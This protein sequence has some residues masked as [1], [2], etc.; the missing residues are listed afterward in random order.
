MELRLIS[1]V[2]EYQISAFKMASDAS[3]Q[4]HLQN[5]E[6]CLCV[7]YNILKCLNDL[8]KIH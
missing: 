4:S 7:V 2:Y 3:A 1:S 6:E 5:K 8:I